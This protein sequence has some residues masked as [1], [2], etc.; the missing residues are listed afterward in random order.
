MSS[1]EKPLVEMKGI[2]KRFPGVV[3]NDHVDFEVKV[4]EVHAL[5]GEN[6]AG[7]TTL[8]NV[9]YGIYLPDEGEVY[10]RG[11]SVT[12]RSPKDAINLGIGMVHQ[13]FT[14]IPSH[15]VAEN[16]ALGLRGGGFLLRLKEVE[17][18]IVELS[19]RYGLKVDP[20][21]KVWQLSIGE[22]QRVEIIKA[23]YRDVDLLILDE[24]TSV[25]TPREA[26][27]LFAVL[28][29]MAASGK[30]VV[31]ITHKL[32]EVFAVSDRVSI[33]R[34]GKM[35]GTLKTSETNVDELAKMMVG[36][37]VSRLPPKT[38]PLKAGD[39]VLEVKNLRA[40]N[41]KGLLALKDVSFT[42]YEGEVF[43]V[44]GVAGSGQKELV[45]VIAGL[46]RALTGQVLLR[47]RDI[48]NLPPRR[49]FEAG[50]AYIPEDRLKVGLVPSLTVAENLILRS[51]YEKPF[52]NGF[53]LNLKEVFNHAKKLIEE[54]NIVTPSEKTPCK[55]LSGGNLQRLILS[56]ELS[57]NAKL[58]LAAYPTRGLDVSATEYVHEVL[59]KSKSRGAAILLISEDLDEVVSLSDR[60]A[61]MF[62]GRIVGVKPARGVSVEELGLM[63]AGAENVKAT[64]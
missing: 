59:L 15:S 21:A 51:Y 37:E 32:R 49:I 30:A 40:L 18:R 9:L 44:A 43:G 55:F 58:I 2:T 26:E 34:R 10:V 16:V 48:T 35:V 1:T 20:K 22:Q 61:V 12:I 60:V 27:D 47:G 19:G 57:S 62:E 54:F 14:L 28:R 38:E 24:P 31:F 25:L 52:S 7:K 36:R 5:L 13:H 17:R 23:L 3:A 46:R 8:M 45:E 50:V 42:V 64:A 53:L 39:V 29:R 11:R 4:G 6:G 33:L 63:M 56:R 41:D